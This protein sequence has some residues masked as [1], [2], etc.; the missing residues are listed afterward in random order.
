MTV[1]EL[2]E[3]ARSELA[4]SGGVESDAA[5]YEMSNILADFSL[6][7]KREGALDAKIHI[8]LRHRVMATPIG[9]AVKVHGGLALICADDTYGCGNGQCAFYNLSDKCPTDDDGEP[10]CS[11]H[12]EGRIFFKPVKRWSQA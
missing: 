8:P 10:L 2:I 3:K 6:I 5:N 7:A 9:K 12:P 11:R 1:R 4:I